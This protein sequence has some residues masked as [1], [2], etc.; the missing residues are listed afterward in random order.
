MWGNVW[1][2]IAYTVGPDGEA[3]QKSFKNGLLVS[4]IS[5]SFD[6]NVIPSGDNI[7]VA[8]SDLGLFGP[9]FNE[10]TGSIAYL[11]WWPRELTPEEIA[12]VHEWV[13]TD[14]GFGGQI[15]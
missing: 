5:K 14:G 15:S 4:T 3:K 13:V 1:Q 11:G 7:H 12:L 8:G 2:T 6:I 9:S 10:F